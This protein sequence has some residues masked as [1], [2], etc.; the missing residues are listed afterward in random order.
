[1]S[2]A[3]PFTIERQLVMDAYLRVKAN[4]GSAG[5]DEMSLEEFDKDYKNYLYKIWN[6]MSSGSYMPPPVMLVE[7]PKK[8]GGVRPLGVPTVAD[9]I[10]QTVVAGLLEKKLEGVFHEDSFGYRPGKSQIQALEKAKVR[11]WK[12]N[13]VVDVDIKGFFDNLP[14]DLLMKAV[15]KHISCKW[16]LLYIE[17]WLVAPL[18]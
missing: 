12:Y 11:C 5:V 13:W 3:K 18:Q 2:K 14:H 4:G 1:M 10:A 7:I 9:R 16:M 6:K 8:D 15:R 17:R